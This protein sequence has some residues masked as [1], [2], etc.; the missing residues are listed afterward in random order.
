MSL[1]PPEVNQLPR[2]ERALPW[3]LGES[4]KGPA[5]AGALQ[6]GLL[7]L[8]P[9]SLPPDQESLGRVMRQEAGQTEGHR[10]RKTSLPP[11]AGLWVGE[12]HLQTPSK[13]WASEDPAQMV[14]LDGGYVCTV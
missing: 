7:G 5:G 1:Q 3:R 8:S 2:E 13:L 10:R 14:V 11:A 6:R 9:Y 12:P 4:L